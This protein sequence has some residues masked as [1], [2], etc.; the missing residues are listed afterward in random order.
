[1]LDARQS[2]S[3]QLSDWPSDPDWSRI[4]GWLA[5]WL[6]Q[7][8]REWPGVSE[9]T[10]P[11]L[12][13]PTAARIGWRVALAAQALLLASG[14]PAFEAAKVVN[15]QADA[16]DATQWH[17][18]FSL[19][20]LGGVPAHVTLLAYTTC[21]KWLH[22]VAL[23]AS[24][25][26]LITPFFQH[27]ET[28]VLPVLLT[29]A[30]A[31]PSTMALLRAACIQG[32]PWHHE[33]QGVFQLG[34]GRHGLHVRGS[35]LDSDSTLGIDFAGHKLLAAQWLRR[36]GLPAPQQQMVS[37]MAHAIQAAVMMGWPVV[38]KP[39]DR[40]RGEGVSVDINNEAAL[41]AAFAHASR[42]SP[43]VLVE[44]QAQGVC[45]RLL[46]VRGQVIYA[47]KRLPV[48]VQG[49]GVRNARQLIAATTTHW[50]SQP[51][52]RRPPPLPVDSLAMACLQQ[53]G[54][55]LDAVIP[56][57]A[58]APLRLIES[59]AEG[60]RD[61]DVMLRLHPDNIDL[62]IR[63]AALFGLDMAGIDLIS[64]DVSVPW[65][66]NAAIVNEVNASPTVGASQMSLDT[67]PAL[68][69][70]LMTND[71]RV[72]IDV[73]VACTG[74]LAW[75]QARQQE[76]VN[77]GLACYLTTEK[78]T[79]DSQGNEIALTC[80]GLIPRC[81]ALLLDSAVGALVIVST[82]AELDLLMPRLARSL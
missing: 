33:G 57:G 27:L 41:S 4:D 42:Y 32:I 12:A 60:G 70:R 47:V 67:M 65:H 38:L 73:F 62:A 66:A 8:P 5:A 56:L 79:F 75:A 21:V 68:L 55:S 10:R 2:L 13:D 80:Q 20:H 3:I 6:D 23:A 15:V 22:R 63:A 61:E 7:P 28:K 34:W 39:V 35:Q 54:F 78:T 36:A 29:H 81:R 1:M 82:Q 11:D 18:D 64:N 69:A 74:S 17:C 19:P 77:Q 44:K 16:L 48:A 58:W 51:P 43:H 30:I 9:C 59:T 71:G 26:E 45:H 46:V 53:A 49:D 52:W 14:I 40:D 31:T 24:A 37:H 72:P 25:D 76:H 50:R